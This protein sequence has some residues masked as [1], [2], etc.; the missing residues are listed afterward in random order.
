MTQEVG[1]FE[2]TEFGIRKRRSAYIPSHFVICNLPLR[3]TKKEVTEYRKRYNQFQLRLVGANGIPGGKIARDMLSL[4]TTASVQYKNI[5]PSGQIVMHYDSIKKFMKSFGLE[6]STK[7]N[8]VEELL[9]KFAGCNIFFEINAQRKYD[10]GELQFKEIEEGTRIEKKGIIQLKTVTNV[11]FFYKYTNVKILGEKYIKGQSI[12]LDITLSAP[13]VEMA[14]QHPVPIDFNVYRSIDSALGKDIYSWIV[15]RNN[16]PIPVEGLEVS[17]KNLIEQFSHESQKN[18]EAQ[19]YQHI[20]EVLKDIKMH[21]YPELKIKFIERGKW[22][23]IILYKSELV[24]KPNDM[25]YV[26]LIRGF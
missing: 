14:Q 18:I 21:Y 15:Y 24:I 11:P 19:N 12:G 3:S 20:I 4:F 1:L 7:F 23:G 5:N 2:R 10:V 25:R 8:L 17:R 6:N 22:K 9:E 13:F 26:P 16:G